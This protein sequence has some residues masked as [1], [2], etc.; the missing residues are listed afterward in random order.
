M[1]DG[2][3]GTGKLCACHGSPYT[4]GTGNTCTPGNCRVDADCG[5]GG[6]CSPA[7][8]TSGCGSLGGYYCHTANDQC[9]ND[10]DCPS[11]NVCT[12]SASAAVWQCAA[13]VL[14]P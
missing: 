6:Y 10:N 5:P 13:T 2:D 7:F 11:A 3:C 4:Y 1:H 14:C 9:V 12:Y 8:N